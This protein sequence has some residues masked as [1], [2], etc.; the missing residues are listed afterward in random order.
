MRRIL[1]WSF[2]FFMLASLP[3][4]ACD[5]VTGDDAPPAVDSG[6]DGGQGSEVLPTAAPVAT[7]EV[8][9]QPSDGVPPSGEAGEA[10]P[11]PDFG[12]LNEDLSQFNSY[13]IQVGMRFEDSA[14]PT[15]S[16]MLTMTT[17]RVVEP[18]AT[19]VEV[20]LSGSLAEDMAELAEGATLTFTEIGETSYS[21]VPGLGC[22][23]GIGGAEM[24]AEFTDVL[25]TDDFLGDIEGAE[26]IGEETING[27]ATYHYRFD[28]NDIPDT[29]DSLREV[30]GD[31]YIS[32]ENEYVVRMV[33]DGVGALDMFG[34]GSDQEG[35]LHL[36]FNVTDVGQPITIEAP[37]E[38]EGAESD[39]PVMDGAVDL[40][41]FAGLTTYSVNASLDDVVTFY[42]EE[43]AALGY[44]AAADQF[45]S[46]ETAILNYTAEDGQSVTVT[47]GVDGD[48]VSVL[49]TPADG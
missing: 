16:G 42:Q 35:N 24:A 4:L 29:D 40:A 46:E 14:D 19:N 33:V 15:Q 36:E 13:R 49:I 23:S 47:L 32:Q 17:A 18:P 7:V 8:E 9:D 21:I 27:V 6:E 3:A 25:D 39:F 20:T 41:T 2:L 5:L 22:I 38:C 12:A 45:I 10:P 11:L 31:V 26:F 44:Q 48:T 1:R 34:G 43:M 28:E 30:T 37:A